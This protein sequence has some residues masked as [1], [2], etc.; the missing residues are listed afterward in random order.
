MTVKR[1]RGAVDRLW[2][3][4]NGCCFHCGKP[5]KKGGGNHPLRRSREHLI[6]QSRGGN[7]KPVIVLAHRSCN[8]ARGNPEPTEDEIVR[9]EAIY[10]VIGAH[11]WDGRPYELPPAV[12]LS[13]PFADLAE[14]LGAI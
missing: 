10:A 6:P 12:A 11:F 5:M 8:S 7:G 3:A 14:R 4:Q 1:G 2:Q 9:A 13:A